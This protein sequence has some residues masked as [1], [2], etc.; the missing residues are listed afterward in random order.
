MKIKFLMIGVLGLISTVAFAQKEVNNAQSEYEKYENLKSQPTLAIS[1]LNKAKE[2]IDKAVADPKT[3]NLPKT[4]AV[5]ASVYAGLVESSDEKNPEAAMSNFTIAAEAVKKA[6]E[7]DTKGENK[8]IIESANGILGRYQGNKGAKEFNDQKYDEAYKSFDYY[9]STNPE[10]TTAILYTGMAAFNAKNYPAAITNYSKL[11]TTKYSKNEAVYN[12]LARAYIM[13][14]DTAGAVKL[15]NEALVKYPKNANMRA[16]QIDLSLKQGKQKELLETLLPAIQADPKN[17]D[18]Y[19]YAG[20]IYSQTADTY[21]K[22]IDKATAATKAGLEAEKKQN[23]DKAA[24]MYKKAIEVDPNYFEANLNLG[25]VYLSPAID[26]F[27]AA[28]K[29]PANKQKE[30]TA[31]M[32][33]ASAQFDLAKPY[34]L[35]A[36]ELN[37]KSE[38]ALSALLT[39]YKGK[40][41]DA[42]AAKINAQIKALNQ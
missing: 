30:Y 34:V 15:I 20:L 28:N 18:L 2:A 8:K 13:N 16:N 17:K 39:Y 12:D 22:R 3:A 29:L 5:K 41:D 26:M 27:N 1:S 7:L 19:Y 11:V 33:K 31:M 38:D 14:K 6:Q 24:E 42:N 10:D 35:K 4:W 23:L 9:R 21:T 40:R 25:F 32:A 36:V 37:P